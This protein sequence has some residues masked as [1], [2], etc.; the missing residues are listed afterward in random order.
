MSRPIPTMIE[1]YT[2]WNLYQ[3]RPNSDDTYRGIAAYALKC[4]PHEVTPE[5]RYEAKC[6]TWAFNYI[7]PSALPYFEKDSN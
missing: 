6:S 4:L 2:A 1:F 7:N 3:S 5:E